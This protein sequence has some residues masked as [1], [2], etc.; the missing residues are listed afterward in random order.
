MP[1]VNPPFEPTQGNVTL[2]LAPRGP[3]RLL[4]NISV[5][6]AALSLAL[7]L[8]FAAR[9][10]RIKRRSRQVSGLLDEKNISSQRYVSGIWGRSR[11]V[12]NG[13]V[14]IMSANQR[15]SSSELEAGIGHEQ[16]SDKESAPWSLEAKDGVRM[17]DHRGN[18]MVMAMRQHLESR[19]APPPPL[20]P[21]TLSTA[22][23]P[24]E[25]RRL[26]TAMS[27]T[28]DLDSS[29]FHQPNPDYTSSSS[30][31]S[32]LPKQCDSPIIPRRR[33]YTKT[34]PLGPPQP[35]S[36]L[37]DDGSIT[38]FSPSSFPSSSPTLPLAPHD[39]F[40]ATEVDVRGEII[41]VIDDTGVGWKRHTRV[42]GG[43]VC[44]A[45]LAAGGEEGFYG[46]RVRPE[47]KR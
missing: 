2:T 40:H 45:C 42:Y 6:I 16:K 38:S 34:L 23:F 18:E 7:A 31:S 35:V 36:I 15:P 3:L 43:G 14:T 4:F 30:S 46:D 13:V 21:P 12:S 29:F 27:T 19:P 20:T 28:G 41:S 9:S 39:A 17:E 37:E 8:S 5:A 24:F 33:S 11:G 25:D 26:S 32:V 44:L 47:E 22:I 10:K 1:T